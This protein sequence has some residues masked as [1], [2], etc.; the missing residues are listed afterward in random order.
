METISVVIPTYKRS[1]VVLDCLESLSQSS[2]Q[3]FDVI[4]VEQCGNGELEKHLQS[5][6]YPFPVKLITLQSR[7]ASQAKNVGVRVSQSSL[8]AFTDDDCIVDGHWLSHI[9]ATFKKYRN[10]VGVFG[11]MLPYQPELHSNEIC[12]SVFQ[13]QSEVLITKPLPHWKYIGFGNNMAFRKD[14]LLNI[15]GFRL[16]L[17]PGSLGHSAEDAE[18]S[19]RLLIK[20]YR[21]VYNPKAIVYHNRWLSQ[22]E[23]RTQNLSY[24]LAESACYFYFSL[25]GYTFAQLVVK[26]GLFAEFRTLVDSMYHLFQMRWTKKTFGTFYWTLRS[27]TYRLKGVIVGFYYSIVDRL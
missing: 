3:Q 14:T 10:I 17:G 20:G 6:K 25:Q 8:I 15:G 24:A 4:I 27:V 2:F 12:P 11:Q 9:Q 13:K 16:W 21:L 1:L 26:S 18:I 22:K 5:H 23:A 19:L 7:G